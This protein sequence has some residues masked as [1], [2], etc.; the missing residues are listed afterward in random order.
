MKRLSILLVLFT[1]LDLQAEPLSTIHSPGKTCGTDQISRDDGQRRL[2]DMKRNDPDTYRALLLEAQRVETFNKSA[3]QQR[4]FWGYNFTT[5]Q[6][7]SLAATLRKTGN[8]T[9]IWVEDAS[10]SNNY[11]NNNVL[12][13]L[14]ANLETYSGS[15]SLDPNRGIVEIDTL[16]FGQPPNYDGDGIIDFLILDIRDSFNPNV[17]NS[18]FIAGY[19]SPTDQTNLTNSN[20][21]DLM[22][23][24]AYPGIFYQNTYRTERVLSTT[25]HEIQHLIHYTYDQNEELWVNEGLSELAG[26]FCGYGLDFPHLFLDDATQ[27][28]VSWGGEVKD[29]AR[30][31][32]WTLY[33]AE[34]FGLTFI[35]NL[36]QNVQNGSVGFNE[37]IISSGNSGNL[38]SVFS[39]WVLANSINDINLDP[40]FGYQRGEARGLK[41]KI[42]RLVTT[43]P[44][45]TSGSINPYAAEYHQF[46]GEDSLSLTF[47]GTIPQNY[48]TISTGQEYHIQTISGN[49]ISVPDFTED[50]TYVL[51]LFAA[52]NSATYR[53]D[54]FAKYSLKYYEIVHDDGTT[55]VKVSFSTSPAVAANRFVVP[56]SD[57]ELESISFWSGSTDYL[58]RVRV[59]DNQPSNLPGTDIIPPLDVPVTV[60]N[61]WISA[62]MPVPP[63]NLTQ[64]TVLYVGIEINQVNKSLGYDNRPLPGNSFLNLGTGW[65]PLSD[66]QISGQPANGVWMIRAVFTGLVVSDTASPDISTEEIL[67]AQNHRNPFSSSGMGTYIRYVTP[68][69]GRIRLMVYNTLGQK[70]AEIS[71][72]AGVEI[73]WDGSGPTGP[74]AAGIYFYRI[75][76]DDMITGRTLKSPFKRMVVLN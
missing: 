67:V 13:E 31:N 17:S 72:T 2:E 70:I 15:T 74:V 55:D 33:C 51:I 52:S 27:S 45:N 21:M 23:L 37:A 35:K 6:Y 8:F 48:L 69:P 11:V 4:M 25:A 34:Q 16:L 60:E 39:T 61:S 50:S 18:S 65:R 42:T 10:W 59:L 22:Y 53:Y 26:T 54:A 30:V 43:F 58:A 63:G 28:L 49:S 9:R 66:F 64:N 20:R 1:F 14:L 76:F 75:I 3:T 62:V 36:V 47:S 29:Y 5:S 19:F 46:R 56:E 71:Q 44:A 41:A 57:L 32:L 24:D 12:D 68:N 73:F 40:R 7:Y 38:T